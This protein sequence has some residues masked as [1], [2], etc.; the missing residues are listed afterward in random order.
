MQD[1]TIQINKFNSAEEFRAWWE[2]YEV[3]QMRQAQPGVLEEHSSVR[4]WLEQ[5]GD[6][7]ASPAGGPADRQFGKYRILRKLG[8]GG[9]GTVYLATDP[10]LNR[11]IALKTLQL[12]DIE[13]TARFMREARSTAKLR[14][15]NIVPVY[16]ASAVGKTYYLSMDYIE[17]VSLADMILDKNVSLTPKRSAQIIRDIALA[18][19]Y[20]HSSDII[21]RDIKPGN[22]LI[23]K[24]GK[25]YLTDF[26]LAKELNGLDK[27]LT[28]S[29]TVLGTPDYMSPEQAMGRKDEVD[30]R[31]DIFSLG[32]TLYHAL[33]GRMPFTGTELYEVMNKVIN[34]D[35]PTPNSVIVVH[36]DIETI[37]LKC[38]EK[39]RAR[40]YQS[41]AELAEDLMRYIDGEPIQARRISA[42]TRVWRRIKKNKTVAISVAGATLVLLGVAIW[43]AISSAQTSRKL[44]AYRSEAHKLNGDKR[45]DEA[46]ITCEKIREIAKTDGDINALHQKCLKE[47]EGQKAS[48]RENDERA[49]RRAEAKAVLDRAEYASLADK[50]IEIAEK[51]LKIDPTFAEAYLVMGMAYNDKF[52]ENKA[53]ECFNRAI[54]LAPES[55]PAYY[56]RAL[57]M[58]D[59]KLQQKALADFEMVVK[60]EPE[61]HIGH[62]ARGYIEKTQGK[63]DEAVRSFTRAININQ[64]FLR[65]YV[66]RADIYRDKKE[67]AKAIS[68]F[69]RTINLGYKAVEIYCARGQA[70]YDLKDM[71]KA[72]ADFT[73]AIRNNSTFVVAYHMRG[74]AYDYKGEPDRAIADFTEA[75]RLDPK[76]SNA[77]YNRGIVYSGRAEYDKA[78]AD[79]SEAIR[80][81]DNSADA[82][83]ARGN[84]YERKSELDKAIA[85]Y[86]MAIRLDP[87][88][89]NVYYNR[90]YA[91][92]RKG[93]SN[94]ALT[95]FNEAIRLNPKDGKAYYDRGL[96]YYKKG[97]TDKAISDFTIAIQLTSAYPWTYF[98]RGLAY[99]QQGEL[100]PAIADFTVTIKLE[101]KDVKNYH[102]RAVVYYAKAERLF[103][104]DKALSQELM[105]KALSDFNKA[106]KINPQF[107]VAY[108]GRG[109][110]YALK[111]MYK[112]AIADGERFL[113]LAPD[114]SDAA[115]MKKRIGEWKAKSGK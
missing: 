84:A 1:R 81:N 17:G 32:A 12:E 89:G 28:M 42:V 103:S 58:A 76:Y 74:C 56:E 30:K 79:Y 9:M 51:A 111:G 18:L 90:G 23:H 69:T 7:P 115:E 99:V 61:S 96:V 43:L 3:V 53:L 91:Y 34:H 49:R 13:S 29:G 39:D 82:Y 108:Y 27:T 87:K 106:I 25:A 24:S 68:D 114:N 57:I 60:Y 67:F 10:V 37:C 46:L 20:A 45:F 71:D 110:A 15:P 21:H 38:L 95:D 19:E 33:T 101:P 41:M 40:R 14:H 16:E 63:F 59:R 109:F 70:Y 102:N 35:P 66:H 8:Q 22:I 48:I 52:N 26:G 100:D 72:V 92:S 36:K 113:E 50:K 11:Q 2:S 77:Y 47:V 5:I 105:D 112:E 73:E 88:D 98:Q 107:A 83:F 31:S 104:Q 85:D 75:I 80:L 55:A 54:E 78:I 4:P 65:A 86:T 94:K 6:I 64:N 44:E 62:F 97:E 93:D